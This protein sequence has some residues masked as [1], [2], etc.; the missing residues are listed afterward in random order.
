MSVFL[1]DRYSLLLVG[2]SLASPVILQLETRAGC[3][4]I[5]PWMR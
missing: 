1:D 2:E 3:L 5:E 4:L